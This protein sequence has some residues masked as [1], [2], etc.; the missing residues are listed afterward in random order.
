MTKSAPKSLFP[1]FSRCGPFFSNRFV[2]E[3]IH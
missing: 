1:E 2:V 3:E